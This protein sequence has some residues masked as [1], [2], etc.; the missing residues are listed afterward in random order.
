MDPY[1]AAAGDAT[2][3]V[4]VAAAVTLTELFGFWELV[5]VTVPPAAVDQVCVTLTVRR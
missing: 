2:V 4:V 3:V 1:T 5:E